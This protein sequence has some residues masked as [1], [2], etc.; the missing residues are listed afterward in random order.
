MERFFCGMG[1]KSWRAA[2]GLMVNVVQRELFSGKLYE[3]ERERI[4]RTLLTLVAALA[5]VASV[6]VEAQQGG[7][8]GRGNRGNGGGGAGAGGGGGRGQGGGAGQQGGPGG[9]FNFSVADMLKRNDASLAT[10]VNG[11]KLADDQKERVKEI[12]DKEKEA[13][14]A[15]DKDNAQTVQ[16]LDKAS[17]ELRTSMRPQQGQQ[18]DQATRQAN[19]DKMRENQEKVQK[20]AE[21]RNKPIQDDTLMKLG[22]VL[23]AE[24]MDQVRQFVELQTMGPQ[25]V[26]LMATLDKCDLDASQRARVMSMMKDTNEKAQAQRTAMGQGGQGQGQGQGGQRPANVWQTL[27]DDIQNNVLTTEQKAKFAEQQRANAPN[28]NNNAN[29][30]NRGN[31]GGGNGGGG[32]RGGGGGGN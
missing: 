24:Q 27:R 19:F 2:F 15:W 7:G 32:N 30:G 1:N 21:R 26:Q 25:A 23:T 8:G 16:D 17:Q 12:F 22:N 14:A 6:A 10:F 5:L 9:G 29:N 20:L 28:N 3:N 13:Y 4:M 11:L 18:V 31:R